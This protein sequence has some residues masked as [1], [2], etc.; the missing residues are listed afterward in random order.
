MALAPQIDAAPRLV[1]LNTMGSM[2]PAQRTK[3]L[4]LRGWILS[5]LF[6]M[7]I[8]GTL[9]G[10]SN[11]MAISTHHGMGGLPAAWMEGHGHAQMFGWIGSFI[12]GIGFYSQ[13]AL[14]PSAI[15]L[16]QTCLSL[17]V[18]GVA[19]R[20]FAN[21]Y[22]WN[23]RLLFP[24]SAGFELIAVLLFLYAASHHKLPQGVA[25]KSTKAP[26]ELWMV[27]VLLG[28]AGLAAA[29]VFNFIE[30]LTLAM[31]GT[32]LSFPHA[33]D[34]KYLVLL[35]WGFLVPV[36]WGFS[37]RWLPAFLS[38]QRP[39]ARIFKAALTLDLL[40]VL[41][42]L[43]G[44]SKPATILLV[45]SAVAIVLALH[46][47]QRPQRHAKV[48]GIHPSFPWFIRIAYLWLVIA[49]FMSVWAAMADL[50]GGIW[51]ASRH[52]LTVGFAATMVFS[53]GP[54]ILP[55]FAGVQNLFSKRLMFFS[56]LLLQIGCT[57]RVSSEPL[58]YEGLLSF[59]W[60]ILPASG[61]LELSAVLLFAINL[62]LTLLLGRSAFATGG[63]DKHI[64]A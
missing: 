46:L 45:L 16:Q 9:L 52:A 29:V 3:S 63:P 51:G 2:N 35:G 60:K 53:I 27:S 42:G 38:I 26:M 31:H 50:H 7:A 13:P 10:F 33:L 43:A 4:L 37:A 34:Q 41:C 48:Q 47:T 62:A 24:I 12:L 30:C 64:A 28:T 40:G 61:F 1:V 39:D 54:R 8:P 14:H 19:L 58:A 11:L 21:I 44:W 57:L 59:A 22:S 6:F 32:L 55:H 18:I 5:G 56:L 25:G 36:V 49:G 20:W 17:W 23:W 15:R